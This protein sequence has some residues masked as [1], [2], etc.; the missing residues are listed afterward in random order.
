MDL[1]GVLLI[2]V[3]LQWIKQT[4]RQAP[5]ALKGFYSSLIVAVYRFIWNYMDFIRILY[6]FIWIYMDLY[7]F[8]KDL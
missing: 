5:C 3:D 7:G 8:Y 1:Y 6:G 2:Y 4:V